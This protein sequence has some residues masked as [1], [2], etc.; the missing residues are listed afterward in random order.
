MKYSIK[1][2]KEL[3]GSGDN[4]HG[5]KQWIYPEAIAKTLYNILEILEDAKKEAKE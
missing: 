1:E 4:A 2:I 5:L 3:I